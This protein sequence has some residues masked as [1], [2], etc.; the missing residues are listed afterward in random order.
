MRQCLARRSALPR[1]SIAG[2]RSLLQ[3]LNDYRRWCRRRSLRPTWRLARVRAHLDA[4]MWR[5]RDVNS[6]KAVRRWVAGFRTGDPDDRRPLLP[7]HAS[8]VPALER[9]R[10]SLGPRDPWSPVLDP[11]EIRAYRRYGCRPLRRRDQNEANSIYVDDKTL[12]PIGHCVYITEEMLWNRLRGVP[13]SE[14]ECQAVASIFQAFVALQDRPWDRCRTC[15]QRWIIRS[16]RTLD[17]DRCRRKFT[18]S[19]RSRRSRGDVPLAQNLEEA[20]RLAV[21]ELGW[22]LARGGE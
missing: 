3:L 6:G 2:I 21:A 13:F 8:Q 19:A 9:E 14:G 5:L 17:C 22:K 1:A 10:C 7:V 15:G 20:R 4:V 16:R 18:S 11:S 12:E